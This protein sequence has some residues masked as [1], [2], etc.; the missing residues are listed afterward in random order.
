METTTANNPLSPELENTQEF[1]PRVAFD[2]ENLTRLRQF[3]GNLYDEAF[4]AGKSEGFGEPLAE[5]FA[6][7]SVEDGVSAY[8]S[9]YGM[10]V[11]NQDYKKYKNAVLEL[12]ILNVDNKNWNTGVDLDEN[13]QPVQSGY[14]RSIELYE[15]LTGKAYTHKLEDNTPEESENA[16]TEP[17]VEVDPLLE[18]Q[19]AEADRINSE[20]LS[21]TKEQYK[22][23]VN[24]KLDNFNTK[25]ADLKLKADSLADS[26]KATVETEITKLED[27]R[28]E[29][30]TKLTD[31][32]NASDL[33]TLKTVRSQIDS[34]MT[35]V[36]KKY[37][38]LAARPEL[39]N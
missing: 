16:E 17:T 26:S 28:S 20:S 38:V 21:V 29:I 25:V 19:K 4:E 33:N 32:D 10:D 39:A 1:N 23:S 30:E 12:S 7:K 34:M 5:F 14:E 2:F 15:D 37:T 8:L 13:S 36:D 31:V 18:A 22:D 11:T 24:T 35:D 6:K 9:D 3:Q 27:K